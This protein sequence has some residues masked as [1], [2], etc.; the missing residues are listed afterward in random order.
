MLLPISDNNL[1][2]KDIRNVILKTISFY[3][4]KSKGYLS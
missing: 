4:Y 3:Q 2:F 1:F